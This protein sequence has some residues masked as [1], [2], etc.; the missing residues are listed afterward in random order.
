[1]NRFVSVISEVFVG[2][3]VL[4]DP[5]F[6]VIRVD[7]HEVAEDRPVTN[8]GDQES[9]HGDLIGTR[10]FAEPV[11]PSPPLHEIL[12]VRRRRL[13]KPGLVV[14]VVGKHVSGNMRVNAQPRQYHA[15]VSWSRKQVVG[16]HV[17]NVKIK[18]V[19]VM[20]VFMTNVAAEKRDEFVA[21][22]ATCI[23]VRELDQV[24]IDLPALRCMC[25]SV[26]DA[27]PTARMIKAEFVVF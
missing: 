6:F 7:F 27:L 4:F 25:R 10:N 12:A 15:E 16:R 11:G 20:F 19:A 26:P 17:R 18:L 13:G 9:R 23:T 2:P 14:L 24:S 8:A 1:M 22:H 5:Q 3:S 21:I